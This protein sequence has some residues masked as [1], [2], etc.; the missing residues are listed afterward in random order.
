MLRKLVASSLMGKKAGGRSEGAKQASLDTF[1]SSLRKQLADKQRIVRVFDIGGSGVKTALLSSGALRDFLY[2]DA[3]ELPSHEEDLREEPQWAEPPSQ[4]GAAPGEEGFR[5]WLRQ[6]L[7]RLEREVGDQHVCFGV[8]IGGDVDHATGVIN[9]WWPG[10][11]HPRSWDDPRDSPL[12]STL[13]GLPEDRTFV[14]HDGEAHLLGC[15]RC[16]APPPSLG[17]LAIGSGVGFGVTD[18]IGAM[19]DPSTPQGMRSLCLNGAPLSGSPYPGIW[20]QWL[21]QPGARSPRT[22]EL[23]AKSFA[24]MAKPWRMP[25]TSLVLGRRGMELAEAAH[26]C[27]EPPKPTQEEQGEG[28]DAAGDGSNVDAARAPAVRAFGE[29]W[30]H[31]MHTQFI[32][33]MCTSTRRHPV[34]RVCFAGGVAERNWPALKEVLLEPESSTL[35]PL[36]VS[37]AEKSDQRP[38]SNNKRERE[39]TSQKRCSQSSR[40]AAVVAGRPTVLPPAPDGSGLIGVALYALAGVGGAAASIWAR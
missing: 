18:A 8:S 16:Y 1:T 33:Q 36:Q 7:P 12:V 39:R 13:M 35:R 3:S 19:V 37:S 22:E 25:W 30:L 14:L 34:E 40:A 23:M 6:V 31:F 38:S 21:E 2:Q 4:L 10:G 27:P 29:Q 15:S 5:S 11:G 24:N 26:D 32:P 28:D 9:D 17:C 20:R